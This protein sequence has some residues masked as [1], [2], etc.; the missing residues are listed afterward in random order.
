MNVLSCVRNEFD[1]IL[2][3]EERLPEL[4]EQ[5]S[6]RLSISLDQWS[7]Q[8]IKLV[9][10]Q[11]PAERSQLIHAAVML[12]F[13]FHHCHPAE[14]M[15]VRR[16]VPEAY[17]P[18]FATHGIGVGAV[19]LSEQRELLTVLERRDVAKRPGHFKLPGGMLEKGE[20]MAEGVV[21]EVF[22]ETGVRTEFQG[23]ISFRHVHRGQ[24]GASNLYVVCR[25]K[26]LSHEITID[27][28]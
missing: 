27:E 4:P 19:V 13:E 10:L 26:P 17:L 18:L 24:F 7:Q 20:H 25:L 3:T 23:L 9:W 2:V 11:I 12:G 28:E 1:G 15:L 5:F 8:G 14:I 16:M 22:E 21:R 6:Q